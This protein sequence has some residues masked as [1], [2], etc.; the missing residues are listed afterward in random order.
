MDYDAV[1]ASPPALAL[2]ALHSTAYHRGLGR[3]ILASPTTPINIHQISDY[4][5]L[6]YTK[7]NIVIVASGAT[8]EE[9]TPQIQEFWKDMPAGKPLHTSSAAKFHGGETRIAHKTASSNVYA[10]AFPGSSLYGP[11]SSSEHIVLAHYLGGFPRIKW[12]NG[13]SA[14]AKVSASLE[15]RANLF[16]TNIGYSDAGLF[17]IMAVGGPFNV[18]EGIAQGL[19]ALRDIAKGATTIKAEELKRA[20]ASARYITYA[21]SEARLSGLEPIGQSVLDT[22]KVPDT[23]SVVASYNKVTADKL[24]QVRNKTHSVCDC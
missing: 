23:D 14:F 24:K 16:A 10:I 15:G 17:C 22:G 3:S 12:A 5:N 21:A 2:S 6:A 8:A 20:I 19:K 7:S 18:A 1:Q 4:G 11:N 9:L 13:H